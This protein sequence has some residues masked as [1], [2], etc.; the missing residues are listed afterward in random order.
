MQRHRKMNDSSSDSEGEVSAP[1]AAAAAAAADDDSAAAVGDLGSVWDGGKLVNVT[2]SQGKKVMKCLHGCGGVWKGWN[3][4]KALGHVL[5]GY[6]DI[7]QCRFVSKSWKEKYQAIKSMTVQRRQEKLDA[8]ALMNMDCDELEER[9][10]ESRSRSRFGRSAFITAAAAAPRASISYASSTLPS[11]SDDG[12]VISLGSRHQASTPSSVQ[13]SEA[14]KRALS[15]VFLHKLGPTKKKKHYHQ[16]ALVTSIG[17][18]SSRAKEEL[19]VAISHMIHACGLPFS[20]ADDVLFQRMLTRAR[21]VNSTYRPPASYEISGHLLDST[22]STYYENGKEALLREAEVFGI[23]IGGDGATIDKCPLFNVIACSPSNPSMVLDV[24]DCS[25]HAADGG[26][27]D[28]AFLLKTMLPK[29]L[30]IDPEKKLI[31][32]ITF[33]GAGNV[34]NAA[35]LLAIHLPRASI[36]PAVEHE[37]SLVFDKIMRLRPLSELCHIAKW[38]SGCIAYVFLYKSTHSL[39]LSSSDSKYIWSAEACSSLALHQDL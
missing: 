36:G 22:F 39:S 26:K 30:E 5:G 27:K 25:G 20:L 29:L 4:T 31:D 7:K 35:K 24:F 6:S 17:K 14:T 11:D 21:D 2:D 32:L 15:N 23:A 19:D 38:V 16:T 34:Q 12:G 10:I 28:A 3:H 8:L 13:Q 18:N 37:V 1:A 33:D 9:V